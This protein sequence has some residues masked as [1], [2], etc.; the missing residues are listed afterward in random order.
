MREKCGKC[1]K[2]IRL[3]GIS[4]RE[5]DKQGASIDFNNTQYLYYVIK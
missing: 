2:C 4:V 5:T 3:T 1:G